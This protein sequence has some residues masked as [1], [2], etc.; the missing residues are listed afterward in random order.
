MTTPVE[1]FKHALEALRHERNECDCNENMVPMWTAEDEINLQKRL[2]SVQYRQTEE[3]DARAEALFLRPINPDPV[4]AIAK[5]P[6][7]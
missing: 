5:H 4:T 2:A 6:V 3:Q 1:W 7:K